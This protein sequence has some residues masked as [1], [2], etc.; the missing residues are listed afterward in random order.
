MSCKMPGEW[1]N[2]LYH[3]LDQI[4]TILQVSGSTLEVRDTISH[5]TRFYF[6]VHLLLNKRELTQ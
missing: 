4:I 2:G 6:H 5:A 1:T 3:D